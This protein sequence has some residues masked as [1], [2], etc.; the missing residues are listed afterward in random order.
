MTTA[1][2]PVEVAEQNSWDATEHLYVAALAFART[3]EAQEIE[4][5]ASGRPD[6]V[7]AM[8]AA[9]DVASEAIG[10]AAESLCHAADRATEA[11]ARTIRVMGYRL[12]DN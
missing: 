8:K 1:A 2:S 3:F 4:R 6:D 10:A 11:Q 5:F 9:S 7:E 12:G